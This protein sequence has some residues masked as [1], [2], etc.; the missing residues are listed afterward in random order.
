[1]NRAGAGSPAIKRRA[2]G[3]G[4]TLPG[5][6]AVV[7]PFPS[8]LV[9]GLTVVL[10]A[11]SG[12]SAA[13]AS[14]LGVAMLGLQA[15]IGA[16]NDLHDA[17]PDARAGR[18]KPIPAGRVSPR[19][20]RGLAVAGGAIGIVLSAA[21]GIPALLIGLAGYGVGLAYDVGLKSRGLGV[22]CFAAALPLVPAY[23]ALGGSGRLPPDY[24][25]L[26]AMAALAGVG[27]SAANGL[28]DLDRDLAAGS[29]SIATRFGPTLALVAAIAAEGAALVA[30]FAT[31]APVPGA[32]GTAVAAMV[33]GTA[34]AAAGLAIS[35]RPRRIRPE[36]GWELQALGLGLV[37]AGWY[38]IAL[39][40]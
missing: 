18:P 32:P 30:A 29:S 12:A 33:A 15:S 22:A 20:A 2:Q 37:G 36:L 31:A 35:G 6:I 16:A 17:V 39:A 28:A 8:S 4:R 27:L 5:P 24:A 1:M 14:L 13:R 7:H 11:L 38:A 10:A 25:T 26:V 34:A 3:A 40:A 23:A 21:A 9:A 19:A